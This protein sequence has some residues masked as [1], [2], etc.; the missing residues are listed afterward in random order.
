[1]QSFEGNGDGTATVTL[2]RDMALR[3][4]NFAAS[5][6]DALNGGSAWS[7][8]TA[9]QPDNLPLTLVKQDLADTVKKKFS[10]MSSVAQGFVVSHDNSATKG[11]WRADADTTAEPTKDSADWTLVFEVTV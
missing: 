3:V 2:N 7:D 6:A 10:E 5:A 4:R 9:I 11:L 8:L 1:V